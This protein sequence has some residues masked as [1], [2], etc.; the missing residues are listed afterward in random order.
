MT[1]LAPPVQRRHVLS[2]QRAL[3]NRRQNSKSSVRRWPVGPRKTVEL[4]LCRLFAGCLV[5]IVE[6]ELLVAL[7]IAD[8]FKSAGARVIISRTLGECTRPRQRT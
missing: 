8:A 3:P 6:D 4:R 5:L 1:N 2:S 7:D